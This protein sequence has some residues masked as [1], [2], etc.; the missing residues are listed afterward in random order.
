[1][2]VTGSEIAQT[3]LDQDGYIVLGS[4]KNREIGEVFIHDLSP[5]IERSEPTKVAVIGTADREDFLRQMRKVDPRYQW[6]DIPSWLMIPD[7]FRFYKVTA[8]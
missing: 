2:T 4:T 6:P 8:E 7:R 3:L 5:T 1:M